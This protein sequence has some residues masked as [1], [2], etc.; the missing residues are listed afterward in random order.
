MRK[1]II[2]R[3]EQDASVRDQVWLDVERIAE[4]EMSPEDPSIPSLRCYRSGGSWR[5]AQPGK[6]RSV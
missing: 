1:R 4:V 6:E 5:A 2:A 3:A